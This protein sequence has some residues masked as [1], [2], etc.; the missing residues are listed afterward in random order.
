MTILLAKY[1]VAVAIIAL[2]MVIAAMSGRGA[3]PPF[4]R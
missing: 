4:W 1:L 2:V 3:R